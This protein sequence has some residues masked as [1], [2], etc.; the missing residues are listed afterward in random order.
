MV[1]AIKNMLSVYR[2]RC[3]SAICKNCNVIQSA[4]QKVGA[5]GPV[6]QLPVVWNSVI[7]QYNFDIFYSFIIHNHLYLYTNFY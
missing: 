5:A 3:L 4:V 7:V 1:P 2:V 6:D